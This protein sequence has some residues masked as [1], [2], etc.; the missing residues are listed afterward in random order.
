MLVFKLYLLITKFI[1]ILRTKFT[2]V[3]FSSEHVTILIFKLISHLF[4]LLSLNHN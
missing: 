2:A 3:N 1:S 4:Q